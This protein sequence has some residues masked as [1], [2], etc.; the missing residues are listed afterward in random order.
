MT[1]QHIFTKDQFITARAR[2]SARQQAKTLTAIDMVWYNTIR[3][4]SLTNGFTKRTNSGRKNAISGG[5][6]GQFIGAAK[7]MLSVLKHNPAALEISDI[8]TETLTQIFEATKSCIAT[9]K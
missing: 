5:E 8:P 2:M 9:L 4:K 3:G 1:T 7:G 6:W